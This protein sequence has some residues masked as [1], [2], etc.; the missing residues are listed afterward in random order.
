MAKN[1][2]SLSI[3]IYLLLNSFTANAQMDNG[4]PFTGYKT[5]DYYSYDTINLKWTLFQHNTPNY[6]SA[7]RKLYEW[8]ISNPT[9]DTLGNA[10]YFYSG[11]QVDSYYNYVMY[12]GNYDT[13][14]I[15]KYNYKSGK[16][17]SIHIHDLFGLGLCPIFDSFFYA[18]NG[19]LRE[20]QHLQYCDDNIPEQITDYFRDSSGKVYYNTTEHDIPPGRPGV[21]VQ[22]SFY[23]SYYYYNNT[24]VW[25]IYTEYKFGKKWM[26]YSRVLYDT[27]IFEGVEK[28]YATNISLYPNPFISSLTIQNNTFEG[29]TEITITDV[30]G[31]AVFESSVQSDKLNNGYTLYLGHLPK[32]IYILRV[33]DGSRTSWSKIIK[34]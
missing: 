3:L 1:I 8:F 5:A 30:L 19:Q 15:N 24:K 11:I 6:D 14:Y 16:L 32:G 7:G 29:K 9:G 18:S 17:V 33:T 26:P 13:S 27:L 28:T 21:G 34:E 2:T 25:E 23:R 12:K 10:V 31:K 4:T 22:S 20:F